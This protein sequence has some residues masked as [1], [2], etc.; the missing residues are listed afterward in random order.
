M[1]SAKKLGD[2]YELEVK[3]ILE[4]RGYLVEMAHRTMRRIFA[5]GKMFYVSQRNDFFGLFDLCSVHPVQDTLWIQVKSDTSDVYKA[6]K[7]ILQWVNDYNISD[8]YEV[9]QRIKRKGFIIHYHSS[10]GWSKNYINLK[11][12][13]VPKFD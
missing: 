11:G 13:T 4:S 6:K 12:K 2:R 5:K 8:D 1:T 9:W 3:H 7:K 10:L